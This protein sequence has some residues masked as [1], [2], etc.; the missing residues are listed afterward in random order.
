MPKASFQ[1]PEPPLFEK[2]KG[3]YPFEV[4]GFDQSIS[5]GGKT[6]GS[7]VM[8][9]KVKFF[10][11]ATFTQPIAQWTEKLIFHESTQWKVN[12][13]AVCANLQFNG[14]PVQPGD[15]VDY[16]EHTTVGLRGWALCEPE[17]SKDQ[18][19]EDGTPKT[20]N[21]VQVWLT[22]EPKLAKVVSIGKDGEDF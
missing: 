20:Y 21:R 5:K 1:T 15:D 8:E 9:L 10:K 16:N 13:F 2:L 6:G 19:N 3:K 22:N 4:V 17:V 11:D 14:R 12:Q 18:K 7:E